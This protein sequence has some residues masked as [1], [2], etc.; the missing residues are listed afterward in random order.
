M[1]EQEPRFSVGDKVVFSAAEEWGVRMGG[2]QVQVDSVSK[3]HAGPGRHRYYGH[4][5]SGISKGTEVG[6]YEDEVSPDNR[7]NL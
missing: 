5:T 2:A 7:P 3:N 1:P 6:F 4:V